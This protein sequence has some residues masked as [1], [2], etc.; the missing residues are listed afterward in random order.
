MPCQARGSACRSQEFTDEQRPQGQLPD[1][2]LAQRL[3]RLEDLMSRLV[4]RVMP[5]ATVTGPGGPRG[6][7]FSLTPSQDASSGDDDY[8]HHSRD[9]GFDVL[10]TPIGDGLLTGLRDINMDQ[11]HDNTSQSQGLSPP[12]NMMTPESNSPNMHQTMSRQM[13]PASGNQNRDVGD[14]IRVATSPSASAAKSNPKKNSS[15]KYEKI[16]KTLHALFPCS[17]DVV[18]IVKTSVGPFY[19]TTLFNSFRDMLEG[20]AEVPEDVA[21]IP[22]ITSHPTVI[23]KRLLQ[24]A[25]CIQQ[26]SPDFDRSQLQMK[27]DFSEVMNDIVMTVS[28]YVTSNDDIVG[29]AEGLESLV[30][31]GLWHSSA[32]NLRKSWLAH[33][34]AMSL[35]QMIGIDQGN[36]RALRFVDTSISPSRRSSV[37]ALWYRINHYDRQL[38]LLL[39]LPVGCVDN[40]YATEDAMKRDTQMERLGKL[41]TVISGRIV[42]R[43]S[44]KTSSEAHNLTQS[45]DCDLEN[46]ARTMGTEWWDEPIM[47]D[48]FTTQNIDHSLGQTIHMILQINH[49]QLLILLHLPYVH[50]SQAANGML[51][52]QTRYDYNRATCLRAS[53]ELLK[54]FIT[55]RGLI[56]S[57][58]SCRHIDYSALFGATTLLLSYLR[59]NQDLTTM[60]A[61]PSAAQRAEDR[62]LIEMVRDRMQTV[63]GIAQDKVSQESTDILGRMMPILDTIDAKSHNSS[64]TPQS[65]G[66]DPTQL[67]MH[68]NIPY[69]GTINIHPA[70][71]PSPSLHHQHHQHSNS[72]SSMGFS[73]NGSS[74]SHSPLTSSPSTAP[75]SMHSGEATPL[76]GPNGG[77]DPMLDPALCG[78][79]GMEFQLEMDFDPQPQDGV[80]EF[81]DLMAGVD[82]WIFQGVDT[83]YW[84]LLNGMPG[85]QQQHHG[86]GAGGGYVQ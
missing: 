80:I 42:Q 7:R 25:I 67:N 85:M 18:T 33:R 84:S 58:W 20:M 31:L 57:P 52:A 32:G 71:M 13:T 45:I 55:F 53:R 9:R 79:N 65:S 14:T 26:L 44:A 50:N 29:T 51:E 3:G 82:D 43:N 10:E 23:A 41:H 15:P 37:D 46:A 69:L 4:D 34:R 28:S 59:Q 36:A 73:S 49:F 27:E 74:Y 21:M 83:T 12:A 11:T 64:S 62:R 68:L 22:P 66:F 17:N 61:P 40:T 48:L 77:M 38:S 30:L 75:T 39:N 35:A 16:C 81:P 8:R 47:S 76:H 78:S 2:R 6:R 5:E 56:Q 54:R 63:A 19:L 1:R 86:F 70:A 60:S 24:L 72:L